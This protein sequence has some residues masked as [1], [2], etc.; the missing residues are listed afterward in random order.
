[1]AGIIGAAFAPMIAIWLAT[2]FGLMYVGYYMSSA[3]VISLVSFL[4]VSKEEHEF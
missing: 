3:A 1:M 4:L 2:D